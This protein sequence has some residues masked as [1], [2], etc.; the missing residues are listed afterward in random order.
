MQERGGVTTYDQFLGEVQHH[1]QLANQGEAQQA[2]RAVLTALGERIS[3]GEASDLAAQLPEGLRGSLLSGERSESYTVDRFVE[4]VAE[5][6]GVDP[7]RAAFHCRAIFQVLRGAVSAGELDQLLAQLPERFDR[8]IT[9]GTE[10]DL[11][12][13]S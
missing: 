10:G 8:L 12:L 9:S 11:R 2:T 4:R 13:D 7:D 6:E 1:A 5:L 3:S